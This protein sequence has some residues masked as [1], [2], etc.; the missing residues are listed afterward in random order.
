MQQKAQ[1]GAFFP[2][3]INLQFSGVGARGH[4]AGDTALLEML[5]MWQSGVWGNQA[6]QCSRVG[7]RWKSWRSH[8]DGL[9]SPQDL[10]RSHSYL[11]MSLLAFWNAPSAFNS[12]KQVTEKHIL[13]CFPRYCWLFFLCKLLVCMSCD[14]RTSNLGPRKKKEK[15]KIFF[16]K[17][18]QTNN[19][20]NPEQFPKITVTLLPYHV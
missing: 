12:V 2:T 9:G 11:S 8:G 3:K 16:K 14:R 15:N 17:S 4:W 6:T 20:K 13:E 1:N 5:M 19:N 10:K 7:S 18:K